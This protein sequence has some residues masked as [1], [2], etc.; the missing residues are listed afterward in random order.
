MSEL[1]VR[2][3][4]ALR[5]AATASVCAAIVVLSL[6]MNGAAAHATT[7]TDTRGVTVER[8]SGSANA[9]TPASPYDTLGIT[10]E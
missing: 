3:R 7:P 2:P 6:V 9:N 8:G 1:M 4:T 5:R 10:W